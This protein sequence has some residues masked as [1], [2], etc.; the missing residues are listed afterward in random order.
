MPSFSASS[1]ALLFLS[2]AAAFT[3]W[4][5]ACS[6]ASAPRST[7]PEEDAA[8][9]EDAG[10]DDGGEPADAGTKDAAREAAAP[11]T[12]VGKGNTSC[13]D[14]C[15]AAGKTCVVACDRRYCGF[16]DDVPAP[17]YAGYACYYQVRQGTVYQGRSLKTCADVPTE[18]WRR[19]SDDYALGSNVSVI[20]SVT[21]CCQ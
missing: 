9:S 10:G 7:A 8:S 17:P 19:G 5:A 4:T 14:T 21:C 3:T 16:H 18:I 20:P 1:R 13:A 6:D 12:V 11:A 15:R 2:L